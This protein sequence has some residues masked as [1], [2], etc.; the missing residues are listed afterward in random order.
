M[1]TNGKSD[2]NKNKS[3][4]NIGYIE[5][6]EIPNEE[7]LEKI[8][9]GSCI[10]DPKAIDIVLPNILSTDF[11]K[12]IHQKIYEA[13]VNLYKKGIAIDIITVNA[14]IK[15]LQ[16][17]EETG[18]VNY[19]M[20]LTNMIASTANLEF[21]MLYFKDIAIKRTALFDSYEFIKQF[22]SQDKTGTEILSELI[23]KATNL[24]ARTN[25][26]RHITFKEKY[27]E[28]L[29]QL[30]ENK[31]KPLGVNTGFSTLD[32][33][34]SGLCA[35]DLTILAA[36]PG[37]GK[38]TFALNIGK[39]VASNFG[40][41]IMFSLEM[42]EEQHIYKLISDEAEVSVIDVRQGH[43]P[44]DYVS[45]CSTYNAKFHFFDRGGYT[46]DEI[47]SFSKFAVIDKN[48]KLI[49][50]DYLQLV[51]IGMYNRKGMTRNDEITIITRKF[52]EL[53]MALNIPIMLLSQVNRDKNRRTYKLHDLRE[54]G[55][56][57]QD[58]DNVWFIWRP[59]EHDQ[60][61]Y[62]IDEETIICNDETAVL[63][64]EKCRLGKTG[65]FELKFKGQFSRFEDLQGPVIVKDPIAY[66]E[67]NYEKPSP[68]NDDFLPF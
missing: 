57:E 32:K 54:S 20:D 2:N 6:Y 24:L 46:I 10:I 66:S 48:V 51:N 9:L 41:V 62:K 43:I 27:I 5:G 44:K 68:E 67:P 15:L 18:G 4:N 23:A 34:T 31:G 8:I 29:K 56:I 14:E 13:I 55:A 21:H 58:A 26:Q 16:Y 64:I 3:D 59:S 28:V 50:V 49:I 7:E 45:N 53:S 19:L 39:H 1:T 38:S 12:T 30:E 61:E 22:V 42:K 35:P 37:E 60:S 65:E 25:I 63:I 36:G 33:I 17:T 47:I 11:Y 40:D 52:K